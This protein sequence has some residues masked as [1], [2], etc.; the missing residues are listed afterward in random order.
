MEEKV[1]RI[2]IEK[3]KLPE[4]EARQEITREGLDELKDSIERLGLLNPIIVKPVNDHYEIVAGVRRFLAC[5]ELGWKEV[6]C[7]VREM[8]QNKSLEAMVHEN[9][10]REDMSPV[11]I[12]ILIDRLLEGGGYTYPQIAKLIGKS[13]VWVRQHHALI[14]ADEEIKEALRAGLI[15]FSHA[16]EIMRHPDPERRKWFLNYTIEYGASPQ[17]LRVMIRDDMGMR[18]A[19]KELQPV[20]KVTDA[21]PY[22]REIW[23]RCATCDGQELPDRM[24]VLHVCY[25]CYNLILDTKRRGLWPNTREVMRES[26]SPEEGWRP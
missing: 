17:T 6:P 5:Q 13:E 4:L 14:K 12:A 18:E 26:W 3:I 16:L 2:P 19:I 24:M 20:Q 9:L 1:E 25:D 10:K 21:K 11:D 7:I 15:K 22:L 23:M 8:D